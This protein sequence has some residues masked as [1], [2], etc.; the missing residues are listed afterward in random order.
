MG[1]EFDEQDNRRL[2][3]IENDIKDNVKNKAKQQGKKYAKRRY[4]D[5]KPIW[6]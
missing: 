4:K 3:N 2:K 1:Y 6:R 5:K